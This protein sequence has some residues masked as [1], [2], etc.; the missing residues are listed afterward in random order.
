[1]KLTLSNFQIHQKPTTLDIPENEITY[2][3]GDSDTGKSSRLRAMRWLCENKPDGGSFVTFK[4]PRGTNSL[5][6]LEEDGRVIERERGKSKNLYRMDG[7]T[8]EAFGRS[9]PEPI[10]KFLALSP[11]AFQLQGE[12]PFLI[13]A[14]PTDAAKILSDACGL[15]VIDT[16]VQF[17]R[18]KKAV[19][20][21]EIRKSEILLE[22]AQARLAAATEQLPLADALEA[23]AKAGDDVEE[24]TSNVGL[25]SDALDDEPEGEV[26]DVEAVR[27]VADTAHACE[28]ER[29]TLTTMTMRLCGAIRNEPTGTVFDVAG[30]VRVA[31]SA[32]AKWSEL[33][34]LHAHAVALNRA[35]QTEPTGTLL[36]VSAAKSRAIEARILGDWIS[37]V[38]ASADRLHRA[39][40]AEPQG[41]II[42]TPPIRSVLARALSAFEEQAVLDKMAR[43]MRAALQSEPQGGLMDTSELLKQ[44]AQIKV[45]SQCGME[46]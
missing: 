6:R 34:G 22:S 36:D 24:L 33:E 32:R 37:D 11:Y 29:G 7:E 8:F 15:G 12:V 21:A 25:L 31:D 18:G 42:D 46:L 38:A 5:V 17:V 40:Q 16:A 26:V 10:A 14:S 20:E 19:A 23:A 35:I 45:C 44:R 43:T 4:Q 28:A 27:T 30:S 1:M 41:E 9:V 2:V 3:E 39:I 13:G